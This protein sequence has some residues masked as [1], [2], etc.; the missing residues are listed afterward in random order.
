VE[1][2]ITA[3]WI[4]VWGAITGTLS[5]IVEIVKTLNDRARVMITVQDKMVLLGEEPSIEY[6]MI[7]VINKGKRPV[8]IE[9]VAIKYKNNSGHKGKY[10]IINH[11]PRVIPA[12]NNEMYQ[13]EQK[14]T[15]WTTIKSVIAIDATGKEY[16]RKITCLL[17]RKLG[18]IT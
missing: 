13:T 15:D 7:K 1:I 9:K 2:K 8:T 12:G 16:Q 6:I 5:I 11:P 18:K 17:R 4:A 3:T 14:D 10:G